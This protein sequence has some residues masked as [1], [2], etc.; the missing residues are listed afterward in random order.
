MRPGSRP[1]EILHLLADLHP[2]GLTNSELAVSPTIATA[3]KNVAVG[4]GSLTKKQLLRS[5]D[6]EQ[7]LCFYITEKGLESAR[8]LA[9]P[10]LRQ[11]AAKAA[12]TTK[13]TASGKG[14]ATKTKRASTAKKKTTKLPR[15]TPSK[16]KA[17]NTSKPAPAT[18]GHAAQFWINGDNALKIDAAA[19]QG[20]L[21]PAEALDFVKFVFEHFE[22]SAR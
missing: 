9:E 17:K 22:D 19:C 6:T 7:G 15:K 21:T 20:E 5:A 1:A 2:Q 16:R 13:R 4:T 14:K 3:A 11:S 12:V 8:A 10:S 18:N